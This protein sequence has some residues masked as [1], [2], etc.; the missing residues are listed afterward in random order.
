[1]KRHNARTV[2]T[3][4]AIVITVVLLVGIPVSFPAFTG[5]S[6]IAIVWA[7][8]ALLFVPIVLTM[9]CLIVVDMLHDYITKWEDRED[10][11]RRKKA[12]RVHYYQCH[13]DMRELELEQFKRQHRITT[14]RPRRVHMH[15]RPKDSTDY[16]C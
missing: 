15:Q 12:D 2:L 6:A 5:T 1:M 13:H 7:I 10:A 3:V 14:Y 16:G 9:L 8:S 4:L 11:Q